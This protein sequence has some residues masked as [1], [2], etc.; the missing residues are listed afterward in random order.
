MLLMQ[1]KSISIQVKW[2]RDH[3]KIQTTFTRHLKLTLKTHTRDTC[4]LPST[5]KHIT[6]TH[7]IELPIHL[8][9]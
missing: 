1:Y 4:T 3:G 2:R 8:K 7:K 5:D 6:S 9:T